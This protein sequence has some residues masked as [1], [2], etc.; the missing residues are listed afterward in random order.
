M[1]DEIGSEGTYHTHLYI[2]FQNPKLHTVLANAFPGAHREN[3]KG[4]SQQNRDYVLKDG[5][6]YNKQPDGTYDYVD[7]SGKRHTGTNFGDTFWEWG[8]MPRE[9]QGTSCE[10]G[11]NERQ[12]RIIRRFFPKGQSLRKYTQKDCDKVADW[13]NTMPRKILGYATS[14]ERFDAQIALLANAP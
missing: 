4:T 13:I 8:E 9:H 14:A 10:R 12:N 7:S 3:V 2:V 6:K 1:C 5:E 11:S